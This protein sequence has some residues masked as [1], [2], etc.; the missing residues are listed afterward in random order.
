ML[1]VI[2]TL[3]SFAATP[4]TH[5][6][7]TVSQVM[8]MHGC[9]SGSTPPPAAGIA[10]AAHNYATITT[11]P[12]CRDF[13]KWPSGE[14]FEDNVI[15]VLAQVKA[16][17]PAALT[18]IYWRMDFALELAECSAYRDEWNAKAA[19]TYGLKMD[20]GTAVKT[21]GSYFIDYSNA[22][23]SAFIVNVLVNMTSRML[24]DGTP[25]VDYLYLDGDPLATQMFPGINAVRAAEIVDAYYATA[26]ALQRALDER[27]LGQK[28]ILNGL[29]EIADAPHHLGSGAAGN[30]VD[31]WSILQFIDGETGQFNAAAMQGAF[32]LIANVHAYGNVTLKIK[33][34]PGP[35]AEQKD[36]YPPPPHAQ[37]P[38][39]A[40]GKQKLLGELFNS[41]LALFLLVAGEHDYWVYSWFWDWDDYVPGA[42]QSTVPAEFF[43][44]AKCE[45]GAP[46]GKLTKTGALTYARE[47]QHAHVHVDLGDRTASSVTF[48]GKC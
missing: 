38:A 34:W 44:Q 47:F 12:E 16:V 37:V 1:H 30:M 7:E 9:Y 36:V 48:S 39:T 31:H 29:D 14:S 8:G 20:N 17:N 35:I 15:A 26:G 46:L 21:G 23:A 28:V 41:E 5:K 22:E 13:A 42:P 33:G 6:W 27:H 3:T 25:I 45:L 43:P 11:A 18:G 40:G 4:N 19:S 2:A 24:P 10:F 32:D